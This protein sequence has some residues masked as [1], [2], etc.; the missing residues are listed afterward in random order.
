MMIP[1]TSDDNKVSGSI[2]KS[3]QSTASK[4]F[5]LVMILEGMFYSSKFFVFAKYLYQFQ[6]FVNG[7]KSRMLG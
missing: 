7:A 2:Y 6:T 3:I 1:I 4:K 5:T